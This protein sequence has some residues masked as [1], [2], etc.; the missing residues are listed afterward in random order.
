M[1]CDVEDRTYTFD[2]LSDK[3]KEKARDAWRR[4]A[5]DYDW[6]SYTYEDAVRIGAL[7]GFEV[8]IHVSTLPSGRRY[9]KPD[10]WFSG[11]SC[12]GD[13]CCWSGVIA[14]EK[15]QGAMARV[16][17]EVGTDD[18]LVDLARVAEDLFG[19]IASIA[20]INRLAPDDD[21]DTDDTNAG[22]HIGMGIPITGTERSYSSRYDSSHMLINI[23]DE[24]EKAVNKLAQY[25]AD[26]IY[27]Q[28][29]AEHDHLLSDE[30]IDEGID[31]AGLSFDEDGNEL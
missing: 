17:A 14:T 29:E 20:A 11:F 9:S 6:W 24:L 4:H 2:E 19:E 30:V 22:V 18:E 8:G 28:L 5:L 31:N 1:T 13:G 7:M 12:Q 25:F 23:S 26:W 10:I 3:A 21:D 15:L 16:A 27:K